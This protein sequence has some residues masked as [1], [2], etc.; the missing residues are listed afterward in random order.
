M[1]MTRGR[2][3]RLAALSLLMVALGVMLVR[4]YRV[5][6]T[7]QPLAYT[8]CTWRDGPV[9]V[10]HVSGITPEDTAPVRAHESVH[11]EQCDRLGWLRYH[12]RNLTVDGKLSLEAP[13][14]CEGA[15][16][17]LRRGDDFLVTRDRMFDDANASFAGMA[18]S[19]RVNVALRAACPEIARVPR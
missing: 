13:G 19:A 3:I 18:D 2:V 7:M 11:A 5:P 1:T 16:V 14:Y 8:E 12:L 4:R 9:Q 17:R 10:M 15:R 6:R